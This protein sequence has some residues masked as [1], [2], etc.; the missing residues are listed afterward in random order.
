[1]NPRVPSWRG[2]STKLARKWQGAR[3]SRGMA[4]GEGRMSGRELEFALGW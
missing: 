1:M 4:R 3:S 2:T